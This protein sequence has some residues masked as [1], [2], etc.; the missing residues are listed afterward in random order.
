MLGSAPGSLG[1]VAIWTPTFFSAFHGFNIG[2]H[3]NRTAVVATADLS[4]VVL[5]PQQTK[6]IKIPRVPAPA[7]AAPGTYHLAIVEPDSACGNPY[8]LLGQPGA[9]YQAFE[10]VG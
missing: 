6:T 1:T 7:G 10:V 4:G 2:P 5:Q 9:A 8:Y 3:C